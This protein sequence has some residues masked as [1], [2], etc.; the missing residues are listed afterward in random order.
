MI[1]L[2]WKGSNR[3]HHGRYYTVENVR[4][5]TLPDKPPPLLIAVGG[6]RT[7]EMAGR[8]GDGL[9]ATGPE[10]EYVR[11]FNAAGGRGKPRYGSVTVCWARDERSAR[12]TAHRVWP[13]AAME[14]SL[15]WEQ[16]LPQHFEDAA[17]LVTEDAVANEIVCGPD[18]EKHV[19]AIGK[20][21]EAG[22]ALTR[23]GS[24]SS[25]PWRSCLG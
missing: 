10:A 17:K 1:R 13:T 5:Y 25:T 24:S 11:A 6:R 15:A 9:L 19:A 18:P 21:V 16:P 8:L 12:K 23:R 20:Y 7:A 22:W 2:L 14:S 3:S 4:L